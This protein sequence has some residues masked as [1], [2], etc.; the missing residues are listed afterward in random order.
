MT[1]AE[2][3]GLITTKPETTFEE[4]LNDIGDWLS[5]LASSDDE[6]D[7]KDKDDD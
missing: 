3:A 4:M 7:G 1:N 2:K 6:E 5:D